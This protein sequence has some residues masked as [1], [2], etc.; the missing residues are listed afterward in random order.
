MIIKIF[1]GSGH[2]RSSGMTTSTAS[3]ANQAHIGKYKLLKTIGKGNFAKV[4]HL[5][6]IHTLEQT[7]IR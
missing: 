1:L 2:H 4:S 6:H 7:L 5:Q 3:R